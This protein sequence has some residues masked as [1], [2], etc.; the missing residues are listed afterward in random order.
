MRPPRDTGGFAGRPRPRRT[1][2]GLPRDAGGAGGLP[3]RRSRP[4]RK[5]GGFV[6]VATLWALA[7]LAVLAAYIDG[8]VASDL[9]HALEA[10]RALE[11]E[12][13]RRSTEATLVYLL[14][15]GR[16]NH[17][18]LILEEEQ[19]F[20]DSLPEGVYLPDHGDGELRVTGAAYAGPDG[21]RFSVQDEGGLVSVN[22]PRYPPFSALL[23]HVGVAESELEGVVARVE[24]FIDSDHSLSLN[25][26][27]RYD[28]QQ[29]GEPPPLNWIMSSPDELRRVLGM[30][31]LLSAAQWE[32]LRPLLTMRPVYSYNF[33]TMRP[34]LLAAL[35]D[36]DEAGV[37]GILEE[38]ERDSLWRLSRIAMLSGVHLNIDELE[39]VLLPTSSM[40]IAVWHESEGSRLLSGIVLTP[41]GGAAPWRKDYRYAEPIAA[42]GAAG[43]PREPLLPP[44]T[45]LLQ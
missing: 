28:Y 22:A 2:A 10:K 24:D 20:A 1:G 17:R 44:P 12:L 7:A 42:R 8:V 29:R 25:G 41:F 31:R 19:R 37:Q 33:N 45:P 43:T 14:S 13:G 15:T 11:A 27:E 34:E 30:D 32:R 21:I 36:L 39:V 4:T 16:M 35:L 23:R 5:A 9:R 6:L 40:R 26:A 18:A 3:R 38:R